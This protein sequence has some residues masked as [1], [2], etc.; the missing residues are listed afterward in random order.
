MSPMDAVWCKQGESLCLREQ[1]LG[2][3]LNVR[4]R[5]EVL[6]DVLMTNHEGC[7]NPVGY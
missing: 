3:L 5:V 1:G 2:E 6:G 4:E 7:G